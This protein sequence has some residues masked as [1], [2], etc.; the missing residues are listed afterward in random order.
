M[1]ASDVIAGVAIAISAITFVITS[2]RAQRAEARARKPVLVFVDVPEQECWVLRNVGNGPALNIVCA[3][4]RDGQW[5]NPV[6]LPPLGNDAS[7]PMPWLGRTSDTG[8]GSTYSDFEG[9]AYTTTIGNEIVRTHHGARLPHWPETEIT[10]Y[11]EAEPYHPSAPMRRPI[12]SDF[13]A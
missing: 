13:R 12:R 5:F 6:R 2:W 7:F 1:D 11:W 8:L 4:R 3:Q 10:R 9:S